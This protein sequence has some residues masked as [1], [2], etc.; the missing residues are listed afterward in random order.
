MGKVNVD[1]LGLT[2]M[3]RGLTDGWRVAVD[4]RSLSSA[5]VSCSG[6]CQLCAQGR[7]WMQSRG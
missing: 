2:S 7:D 6:E 3:S 1:L 4:G 5:E